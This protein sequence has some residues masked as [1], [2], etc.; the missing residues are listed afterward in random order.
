M[1]KIKKTFLF[2]VLSIMSFYTFSQNLVQQLGG[3]LAPQLGEIPIV[4]N[5]STGTLSLQNIQSSLTDIPF[6]LDRGGLLI[7]AVEGILGDPSAQVPSSIGSTLVFGFIPGVEVL[8]DR[9]FD[10]VTYLSGGGTLLSS[11]LTVLPL[12]P[13]ISSPLP[14][15]GNETLLLDSFDIF[16]ELSV[17]VSPD[18]LTKE[19]LGG[20]H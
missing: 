10:I 16:N 5:V 2:M 11:S 20:F 12:I 17:L 4:G 6:L 13:L 19:I 1:N 8:F 7:G 9:P 14:F 15:A 18:N 3:I